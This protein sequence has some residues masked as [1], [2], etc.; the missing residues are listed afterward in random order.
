VHLPTPPTVPADVPVI[1]AVQ[2]I[3]FQPIPPV[4]VPGNELSFVHPVGM[5]QFVHNFAGIAYN[6]PPKNINDKV[7]A[8]FM[9]SPFVSD[10]KPSMND[11]RG[12][13]KSYIRMTP[14][15]LGKPCG[16]ACGSPA[17]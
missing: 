1:V 2:E 13:D 14:R 11:G 16:I 12:V 8:V 15:L 7:Q 17:V 3:L 10:K 9:S 6:V 4:N 5:T